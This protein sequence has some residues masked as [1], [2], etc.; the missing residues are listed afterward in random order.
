M[1]EVAGTDLD[2]GNIRQALE[3]HRTRADCASCHALFDPFGMAMEQFDAI[4]RYRTTY[5]DGSTIDASTTLGASN[6]YPE[7]VS[8]TGLS[9][10][11]E[12]VTNDPAFKSCFAHKL[13]I[14]GLGRS[15]SGDDDAWIKQIEQQW[16]QGDLTI[17]RLIAGLTQSVP[18]RNSG[19]VK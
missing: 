1:L 13:F 16:E 3:Q 8:F 4:G 6:A 9:G 10:A 18:F 7:G 15:P 17:G 14:Y 12:V 2:S 11:A 5:S 19:D